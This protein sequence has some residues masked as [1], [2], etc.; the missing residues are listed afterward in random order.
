M[1]A[2]TKKYAWYSH[3]ALAL[4]E[5]T[6]HLNSGF[7]VMSLGQ[8]VAWRPVDKSDPVAQPGTG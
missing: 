7:Y 4:G 8:F 5:G 3:N 2:D 1:I 6:G